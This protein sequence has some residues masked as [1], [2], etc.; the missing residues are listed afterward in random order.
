MCR[1]SSPRRTTIAAV[2]VVLIARVVA[3]QA[4]LCSL[5]SSILLTYLTLGHVPWSHRPEWVWIPLCETNVAL[6]FSGPRFYQMCRDG[7][8]RSCRPLF[9][10]FSSYAFPDSPLSKMNPRYLILVVSC[11]LCPERGG[12]FRPL[13][14]L[15]PC[16]WHYHH[17]LWIDW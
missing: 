14:S 12:S 7:Y 4:N 9:I 5:L 10:A 3:R 2:G 16:E 11:S 15:F 6:W 13:K 17:L 1:G 8:R